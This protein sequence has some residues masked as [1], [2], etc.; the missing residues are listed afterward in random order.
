MQRDDAAHKAVQCQRLFVVPAPNR[1]ADW[2]LGSIPAGAE[3]GQACW[4]AALPGKMPMPTHI[5]GRPVKTGQWTD[6]EDALLAEWQG[7][8]GNRWSAV[9]KKVVGR[10]GQQC[11]QRWR[12]KV[13]PNIRKD[14]WTDA[15]DKALMRLVKTYGCAWA[16]ISRLMDGRTDQQCMGRWRRHLDPAIRRDAWTTREDAA[17]QTLYTRHGHQWASIAKAIPGRTAQQCRAR[18][19]QLEAGDD[20]TGAA[21]P[22]APRPKRAPRARRSG[23]RGGGSS[24]SDPGSDSDDY[25]PSGG[26]A[27]RSGVRRTSAAATAAAVAAAVAAAER[28]SE[29]EDDGD[30]E[31]GGDPEVA[32]GSGGSLSSD[33]EE[34]G[35]EEEEDEMR[36]PST[37]ST[38]LRRAYTQAMSH[39]RKAAAGGARRRASSGS[40]GSCLTTAPSAPAP[41][42]KARGSPQADCLLAAAAVL[43][44]RRPQDG[45]SAARPRDDGGAHSCGGVASEE[46]Q[47]RESDANELMTP[48]RT[49]GA[50]GGCRAPGSRAAPVT[51][52]PLFLASPRH[53][54]SQAS[55]AKGHRRETRSRLQGTPRDH[56]AE[57]TPRRGGAGAAGSLN[58]NPRGA[59]P[60]TPATDGRLR[61]LGRGG[62]TPGGNAAA[63]RLAQS[64]GINI[65]AMLA[66]PGGAS[67]SDA[68]QSPGF[69]N[70]G[71]VTPEWAKRKWPSGDGPGTAPQLGGPP[72]GLPTSSLPTAGRPLNRGPV[73]RRLNIDQALRTSASSGASTGP[74]AAGPSAPQLLQMAAVAALAAENNLPSGGALGGCCCAGSASPAKKIR[75]GAGSAGGDGDV[76]MADAPASRPKNSNP[77][78]FKPF[79]WQTLPEWQPGEACG[80]SPFAAAA[81]QDAKGAAHEDAVMLESCGRAAPM[82]DK[83][84]SACNA[85]QAMRFTEGLGMVPESAPQSD[86]RSVMG[87]SSARRDWHGAANPKTDPDPRARSRSPGAASSPGTW[88]SGSPTGGDASG[89]S[90]GGRSSS[91]VRMRLHA[92]LEDL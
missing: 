27:R 9:A 66:S 56:A 53:R 65:L 11:A 20:A 19:F 71:M 75:T 32:R 15:E 6:A 44:A 5:N 64:P 17:L 82:T 57:N 83:E 73:A 87:G 91:H 79:N 21:A 14:K 10:T 48:P 34:D 55:E 81:L 26:G 70:L 42:A 67:R 41:G 43:A 46:A 36:P 22:A 30:A 24:S 29:G 80:S 58:P 7:K 28:V 2:R 37:F 38:P 69:K 62:A 45:A 86:G 3:R 85:L 52:P 89:G 84:N 18:W 54:L 90:G 61:V 16:E 88:G 47:L 63:W 72:D 25:V 68:L 39:S 12:H 31:E 78:M 50:G 51:S 60:R 33:Y 49:R 13:N 59:T 76:S 23:A 8:L 1:F 74:A 35:E 4:A 77:N 40:T 92:L